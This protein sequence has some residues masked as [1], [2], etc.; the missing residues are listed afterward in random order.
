MEEGHYLKNV[1]LLQTEKG[2]SDVM[3]PKGMMNIIG[4]WKPNSGNV[5][6]KMKWSVVSN[7]AKRPKQMRT[8]MMLLNFANREF[9]KPIIRAVSAEC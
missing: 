7:T 6:R 8:E 3:Q 9:S 2:D 4:P 1:R 5:S